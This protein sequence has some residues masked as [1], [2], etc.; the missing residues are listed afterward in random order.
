MEVTKSLASFAEL[1]G[2]SRGMTRYEWLKLL[3]V[4][5]FLWISQT[6]GAREGRFVDSQF[7]A[8]CCKAEGPRDLG[9]PGGLPM[10]DPNTRNG[11]TLRVRTD[12]VT[13]KL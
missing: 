8:A 12:L 6:R 3:Q 2:V 1:G 5:A 9:R 7:L 11:S 10:P 4:L 13:L